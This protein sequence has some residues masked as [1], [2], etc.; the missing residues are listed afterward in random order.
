MGQL[1][2]SKNKK[3]LEHLKNFH[4]QAYRGIAGF[5]SLRIAPIQRIPRYVLL[6]KDLLRYTN[7]RG[8]E[9]DQLINALHEF[10]E[11]GLLLNKKVHS[12]HDSLLLQQLD[13]N[14]SGDRNDL[15]ISS[16]SIYAHHDWSEKKRGTVQHSCIFCKF[17][18]FP[19]RGFHVCNECE[20]V[21]HS[22]GCLDHV[23]P[24]CNPPTLYEQGRK[25][26]KEYKNIQYKNADTSKHYKSTNLIIFNDS[27]FFYYGT[28]ENGQIAS[29][30]RWISTT[31]GKSIAIVDA[32][33]KTIAITA[34]RTFE[35][36]FIECKSRNE[37]ELLY[38]SIEHTFNIWK[39]ENDKFCAKYQL[40]KINSK[41]SK[42]SSIPVDNNV[43][44]N[45]LCGKD[46][47]S[48]KD[49]VFKGFII[50]VIEPDNKTQII[51]QYEDFVAFHTQL[52]SKYGMKNLPKLPAKH[53][54]SGSNCKNDILFNSKLSKD[55][56]QYLTDILQLKDIFTLPVF[57]DFVRS[58]ISNEQRKITLGSF[59]QVLFDFTPDA[60]DERLCHVL[61]VKSGDII[62]ILN[63]EN[64]DWWYCRT[65]NSCETGYV[66]A[67]FVSKFK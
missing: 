67:E 44:F 41:T 38:A 59:G 60:A 31:T 29:M 16:A 39:I 61:R 46:F 49:D 53:R 42:I 57:Q 36:H 26:I 54:V 11:L 48:S 37:K 32:G 3:F 35:H 51:K 14:L 43:Y 4:D 10:E 65:R 33:E 21:V 22:R 63:E 1:I 17:L 50:E 40:I 23:S 8:K 6:L 28:K 13:S 27:L 66:P 25:F 20:K 34:P 58:T 55:L 56:Q 45:V 18:I 47:K 9:R 62:E 7:Q 12:H 52:R 15:M 64:N 2:S 5:S 19:G 30:I 24:L